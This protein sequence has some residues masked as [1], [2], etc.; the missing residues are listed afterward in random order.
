VKV[1]FAV[2]ELPYNVSGQCFRQ[3]ALSDF[4][5]FEKVLVVAAGVLVG[6]PV[7]LSEYVEHF[8]I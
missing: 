5:E 2:T 8:S 6:E 4:N 1:F 3:E 7:F